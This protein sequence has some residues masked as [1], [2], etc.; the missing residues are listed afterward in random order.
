[1]NISRVKRRLVVELEAGSPP[2]GRVI[3][4]DGSS[5]GFAGWTELAQAL[6]PDAESAGEAA[7]V[8]DGN[9]PAAETPGG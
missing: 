2:A 7:G 1:M 8:P 9:A 6:K 4:A 3:A 5:I